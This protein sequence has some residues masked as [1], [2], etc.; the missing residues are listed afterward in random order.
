MSERSGPSFAVLVYA[1]SRAATFVTANGIALIAKD[2]LGSVVAR[3]DGG[4][5]LSIAR[6]GYPSFVPAGSGVAAQSSIAFFPGYPIAMRALSASL[7]ISPVL[8]GCVVSLVAGLLAT[9]GLWH[10]AARLSDDATADRTVV[11][12]AFMPSAFVMSM[13]YADALFVCLA[14]VCLITLLDR[15]WVAAGAAAATAGLVRPTA[16]ALVVA[17]AWAAVVAIR[18]GGSR[19]ALLA[20]VIAPWGTLLYLG[21]SWLHTGECLAFFQVQ[22]RGWGNRIDLG[23]ANVRATLRNLSETRVTFFVAVLAIILGGLAIGFW[24]LLRSRVPGFVIAYVSIVMALPILATNPVS[25]PRFFLAAFPLLIPL[26]SRISPRTFLPVA[27]TSG[28]LM[29]TLFFV[30]GLGTTPP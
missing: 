1:L 15:R 8:A 6:H 18:T 2:P 30:T 3:W 5:Y 13:V 24:L 11:L 19:R 10:L 17:C 14:V 20:P 4:W 22:S 28:V 23:G 16:I 25:S 27:A 26:A 9:V 12:F 7:G 29:G 21:Y